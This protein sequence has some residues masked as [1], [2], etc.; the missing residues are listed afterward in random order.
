MAGGS[1][2]CDEVGP[3]ALG[4]TGALERNRAAADPRLGRLKT[5]TP[6]KAGLAWPNCRRSL[7]P[8][9]NIREP[10][11][12][13]TSLSPPKPLA[14]GRRNHQP[15]RQQAHHHECISSMESAKRNRSLTTQIGC[16]FLITLPPN[17]PKGGK[18]PSP[19][20]NGPIGG[21]QRRWKRIPDSS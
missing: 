3:A 14:R 21:Y 8:E 6:P 17:G 7:K 10:P 9:R 20:P 11:R 16:A 4:P 5:E 19:S 18:N 15:T 12:F 2:R 1:A 13:P